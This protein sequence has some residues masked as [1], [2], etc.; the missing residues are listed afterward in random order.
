M[1]AVMEALNSWSLATT[2]FKVFSEKVEATYNKAAI[3]LVFP[4]LASSTKAPSTE[5]GVMV[6]NLEMITS[7]AAM[8]PGP[9]ACLFS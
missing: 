7:K 8:T 5:V 3:G 9:W 6:Y 4:I 2:E 1:A